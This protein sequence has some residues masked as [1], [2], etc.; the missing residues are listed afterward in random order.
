MAVYIGQSQSPS[1]S[2]LRPQS[3][4]VGA[5]IKAIVVPKNLKLRQLW[6]CRN[7]KTEDQ[8][9]ERETAL[10]KSVFLTLQSRVQ[11][12]CEH[13]MEIMNVPG[14]SLFLWC[15]WI[16]LKISKLAFYLLYLA[17]LN[18]GDTDNSL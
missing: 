2:P 10:K 16:F 9:V 5:I 18:S 3:P 7:S 4:Y 17:I 12:S 15:G 6:N 13:G 11:K 8:S 14:I 1:S